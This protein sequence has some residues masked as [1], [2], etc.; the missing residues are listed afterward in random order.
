MANAFMSVRAAF[1]A[2]SCMI[3][4]DPWTLEDKMDTKGEPTQLSARFE[5]GTPIYFSPEQHEI[6]ARLAASTDR[7][8]YK[9]IKE[10]LVITPATSDLYSAALLVLELYARSRGWRGHDPLTPQEEL[11]RCCRRTQAADVKVMSAEQAESWAVEQVGQSVFSNRLRPNRIDGMALLNLT[12]SDNEY[13]R[14]ELGGDMSADATNQAL[15]EI[16]RATNHPVDAMPQPFLVKAPPF[17]SAK[18]HWAGVRVLCHASLDGAAQRRPATA[19]D[20]LRLLGVQQNNLSPAAGQ[21]ALP[22]KVSKLTKQTEHKQDEV[23]DTLRGLAGEL[24]AAGDVDG[25]LGALAEVRWL[26]NYSRSRT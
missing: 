13:A 8:D 22:M 4:H 5:G 23:A 9:H 24:E 16:R 2:F 15:S 26:E 10:T 11:A 17:S 18:A 20:A 1:A 3:D 19:D 6:K 25:A 21:S 14:R 7:A 12:L